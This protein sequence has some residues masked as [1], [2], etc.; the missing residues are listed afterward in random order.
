MGGICPRPLTVAKITEAPV[1]ND[2]YIDFPIDEMPDSIDQDCSH[3]LHK[4][5]SADSR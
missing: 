3:L 1:I 5:T 2:D 4:K